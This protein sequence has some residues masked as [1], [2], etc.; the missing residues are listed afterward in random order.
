MEPT[1][2]PQRAQVNEPTAL[3][4]VEALRRWEPAQLN[5]GEQLR[6]TERCGSVKQIPRGTRLSMRS[7]GRDAFRSRAVG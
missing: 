5:Y 4:V 2:V 7:R 3:D 1:T 6:V